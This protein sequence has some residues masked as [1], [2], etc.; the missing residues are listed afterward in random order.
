LLRQI[1]LIDP[2]GSS[3]LCIKY[4]TNFWFTFLRLSILVLLI[5]CTSFAGQIIYVDDDANDLNDGS[6][7]ADAYIYLQDALADANSSAKPIEIRV[8]QGIYKPDQGV[9]QIPGDR[10][11]TFQLIN[12]VSLRGGYAGTG[13]PDPNTRNIN[14]YKTILSGDLADNDT[15][16]DDPFTLYENPSRADNSY[17]VVTALITD[18]NVLFEGFVVTSAYARNS[19]TGAG[20][21]LSLEANITVKNCLFTENTAAGIISTWSDSSTIVDCNFINNTNSYNGGGM[22]VHD[23]GSPHLIRC[24]FEGNWARD[25]GGLYNRSGCLWLED[26]TFIRNVA[27]GLRWADVGYGGGLC[28]TSALPSSKLNNCAFIANIASEG[29]GA[30]F[31]DMPMQPWR[32]PNRGENILLT[33]CTFV[34]N[35][36]SFGGAIRHNVSTLDIEYSMF[37]ENSALYE[38]G[39][40]SSRASF[41]NLAHCIFSGNSASRKGACISSRGNRGI[42]WQGREWPEEFVLTLNSCTFAGNLA[43]TGRAIACESSGSQDLD[44]IIISNC[45][46]DNGDNEIHNDE[47]TKTTIT[48]TNLRSGMDSVNDPCNAVSWGEGNINIDP[49]FSD[50]GYWDPNGTPDD[51]DDDFW[52]DGDYHLKSQAG[53]WDLVS[54]SW[55]QDDV[56]S[57]CIDAGDPNTPVG[58]EP[59]PNGGIINM[60]AYGGTAEASKSPAN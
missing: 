27:S 22:Y 41:T 35:C 58:D 25:G 15:P 5:E 49:L 45:I 32:P 54:E 56:T 6:S 26:C 10:I 33:G 37:N 13:A 17:R 38:G 34:R 53:R 44:N 19:D 4:M 51:S 60:G 7:W 47:G 21:F 12:G 46:L 8:A 2:Y 9:N 14:A 31:G 39:A 40:I 29:G 42:I 28:S 1:S 57:P 43:P 3:R 52:I 18:P 59:F 55:V 50:P 11:T 30:Y 24:K 23:G 36:A 16:I 48:Y 20:L